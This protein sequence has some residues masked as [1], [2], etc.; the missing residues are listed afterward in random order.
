MRLF[1]IPRLPAGKRLPNK[2]GITLVEV[3]LTVGVLGLIL[4]AMVPFI[5]TVHTSWNLGDRRIQLQQNA[6]VGLDTLSRITRQTA[7]IISIPNTGSGSFIKLKDPLDNQTLIFYH[8]IPG[9]PYYSGNSSL[10]RENDLVMAT[11]QPNPAGNPIITRSLLAK[12]LSNFQIYFKDK[13]GQLTGQAKNVSYIDISLR[14]SDPENLIPEAID[15]FSSVSIRAELKMR[16]VWVAEANFVVELSTENW[17]PGFSQ[18]LSLSVNPNTQECWVADTGNNR[19]KK[20][21]PIGTLLLNLGG[22]NQPRSVAVN[23][24]TGECW[25]ADTGNNRIIKLS[26]QGTIL[27]TISDFW[28]PSC[29]TLNINTQECWVADTNKDRVRKISPSGVILLTRSG[30]KDPMTV[31][32]YPDTGVCWVADTGN[33][34]VKKLSPDKGTFLLNLRGFNHPLSLSVDYATGEC[35]VADTNNNQVVKLDAAGNEEL[36]LSGFT[37]PS[38]ISISP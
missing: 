7:K 14:V 5:R 8:N 4:A 3:L 24:S 26:A 20:I 25:V 19:V 18:P 37:S 13:N 1:F 38:A 32:V 33:N 16:P 30:L 27:A 28:Q 35:W 15:L 6:R 36:R 34:R 2:T 11:E 23:P 17:I 12:S 31:S 9:S 10:I 29:V 22:F 21:S